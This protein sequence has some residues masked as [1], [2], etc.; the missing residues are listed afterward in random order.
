MYNM[1]LLSNIHK[2]KFHIILPKNHLPENNY[3]SI[4]AT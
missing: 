1:D 2:S 4:Y 3:S